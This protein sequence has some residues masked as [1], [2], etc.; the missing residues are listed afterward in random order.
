MR[1]PTLNIALRRVNGLRPGFRAGFG[2][3]HYHPVLNLNRNTK[4]QACMSA[5]LTQT[6]IQKAK[7]MFIFPNKYFFAHSYTK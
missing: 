2:A 3:Q 6:V 4:L 5:R 1:N 7:F